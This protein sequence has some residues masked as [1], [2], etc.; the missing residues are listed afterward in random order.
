MSGDVILRGALP[1]EFYEPS[2][3]LQENAYEE[4]QLKHNGSGTSYQNI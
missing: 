1:T 3:F 4:K 2:N